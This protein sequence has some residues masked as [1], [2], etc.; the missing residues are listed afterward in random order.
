[1]LVG[2]FTTY[3]KESESLGHRPCINTCVKSSGHDSISAIMILNMV[4][5]DHV[6]DVL[7]LSVISHY[8]GPECKADV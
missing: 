8:C 2:Y 1:M 5:M 7:I 3:T 4:L 6:S